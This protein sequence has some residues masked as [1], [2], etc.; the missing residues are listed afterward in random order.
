LECQ[1]FPDCSL[2]RNPYTNLWLLTCSLQEAVFQVHIQELWTPTRALR[3]TIVNPFC[4]QG[5]WA[6]S[7]KMLQML[8]L[9]TALTIQFFRKWRIFPPTPG[10]VIWSF[11]FF[12]ALGNC[13][14]SY[15]LLRL[16]I[17]CSLQLYC[18]LEGIYRLW[19]S[20]LQLLLCQTL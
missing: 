1:N 3:G 17:I 4:T 15:H 7:I 10:I 9:G 6:I 19:S 14:K 18:Y 20:P 12:I 8:P 2:M 11:F 16:W 5:L 13:F